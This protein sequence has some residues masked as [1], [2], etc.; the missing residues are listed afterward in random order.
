MQDKY[1]EEHSSLYTQQVSQILTF[2]NGA[3]KRELVCN[4][5]DS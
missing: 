3:H 2:G 4:P 1:Y 5:F